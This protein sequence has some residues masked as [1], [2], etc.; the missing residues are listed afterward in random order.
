MEGVA[1]RILGRTTFSLT[2]LTN[3]IT[4]TSEWYGITKNRPTETVV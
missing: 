2:V 1:T 3:T 4:F